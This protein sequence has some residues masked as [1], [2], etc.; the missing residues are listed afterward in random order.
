MSSKIEIIEVYNDC[1]DDGSMNINLPFSYGCPNL[2]LMGYLD[3]NELA[4]D[5][6]NKLREIKDSY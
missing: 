2:N 4:K 3:A 1:N 5:I 6:R